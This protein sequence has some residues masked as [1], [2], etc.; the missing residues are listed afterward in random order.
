M[1]EGIT[2]VSPTALDPPNPSFS[3]ICAFPFFRASTCLHVASPGSK[4]LEAC[5]TDT[6][7]SMTEQNTNKTPNQVSKNKNFNQ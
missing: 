3:V 2:A 5:I 4:K 6:S 7:G 1:Q